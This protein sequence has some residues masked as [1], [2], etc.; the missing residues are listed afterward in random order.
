M[1]PIKLKK[2]PE[3][4]SF[5][6]FLENRVTGPIIGVLTALYILTTIV[7]FFGAFG[8]AIYTLMRGIIS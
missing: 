8:L 6:W 7:V 1:K 2:G 3:V 5:D 4:F